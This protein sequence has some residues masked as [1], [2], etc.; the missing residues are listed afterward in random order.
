MKITKTYREQV[1]TV[2]RIFPHLR[3]KTTG[4][5]IKLYSNTTEQN[6]IVRQTLIRLG[7]KFY[8]ITPKNERPIK[9][10]IKGY[11][12][13]ADP[14]HIKTDLE[15]E[16]FLPE[17]CGEEHLTKDCP[18]KQRLE[19]KF[20]INCQVYGHMANWYGCPCFPKPKK[21]AAKINRNSYTNLYNS[22]VR[23]N[24]S[25]AQVAKNSDNSKTNLNSQNKPQMAP[26]KP[27][28]SNQTEASN[29]VPP[30]QNQVQNS[31]QAINSNPTPNLN[32][33]TTQND[34]P[35][36]INT[37]S[38]IDQKI[39]EFTDTVRSA[40]SHASR[41]IVTPHKSYTPP[42]IH[43]L[44]KQKNQYRNLCHR[45]LDPHYKTL[46]NKAQK[47]VKKELR[48]YSNENWTA[49]LQAL[50][51]QDNSLWAVQKFL[52]NKRS[53]IPPLNCTTG[54]AVTDNQKANILA[55]SI[56]DN[57]TEN[58][59]KTNEF[60]DDDELIKNT[61]NSFL[62]N[63]PLATTETAYPSEIISYIKK[64]NS[65]KAPGRN[66]ELSRDNKVLLYTAVMRPILAYGCPVWDE[67]MD[68]DCKAKLAAGTVGF[69]AGVSLFTDPNSDVGKC[70]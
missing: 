63:P 58:T 36:T 21:G 17:R 61:V 51:A 4:E 65:K 24:F 29:N 62:S 35:N 41:P 13:T 14:N 40:H 31:N 54:T 52:K 67:K 23:P 11:P 32:L 30:L 10:V 22:F 6:R 56:L 38:D 44:I 46:Y 1:D 26:R 45:T 60:D 48:N 16:G 19:T 27:E 59:R 7:Y 66:S 57:F 53:D 28:T 12:K 55:N 50:S 42:Y 9:V 2:K 3:L 43:K 69:E 18:I 68:G 33:N 37:H 20:C 49:R 5:Y 70:I 47:N 8:V 25:Y 15:K 39:T 34:N 64:S